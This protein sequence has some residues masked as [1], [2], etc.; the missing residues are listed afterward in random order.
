VSICTESARGPQERVLQVLV[1]IGV[2]AGQRVNLPRKHDYPLLDCLEGY[3]QREVG[4]A[5]GRPEKTEL[6]RQVLERANV[7]QLRQLQDVATDKPGELGEALRKLQKQI[8]RDV[9]RDDADAGAAPGARLHVG[10][11]D[12][13][14]RDRPDRLAF[15]ET[16]LSLRTK[17][18]NAAALMGMV[19]R[20]VELGWKRLHL[21]GTPEFKREAWIIATSRGLEVLGYTA[22]LGDREAAQAERKRLAGSVQE[23]QAHRAAGE[24][25][26]V[27]GQAAK[28]DHAAEPT[29][30][31]LRQVVR[32][33]IADGRL[34]PELEERL[35]RQLSGE[36]KRRGAMG[37]PAPTVQTW[38]PASPRVRTAHQAP[39]ARKARQVQRER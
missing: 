32:K 1:A 24:V 7:N 33:A 35:T 30:D 26:R 36:A 5:G 13:W 27:Q 23:R 12:Y 17:E 3:G 22:T 31:Q 14:L 10:R 15:T 28:A 9:A 19:D 20:A 39:D 38:D 37:N 11:R 8:E 4:T 25:L 16:W 29:A 21:D 18:H 34:A 6:H 2:I